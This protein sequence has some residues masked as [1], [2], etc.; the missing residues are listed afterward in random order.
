MKKLEFSRRIN[1]ALLFLLITSNITFAQIVECNTVDCIK[2]AMSTATPGTEIVIAEGNYYPAGKLEDQLGKFVK[3]TSAK[4]G[5]AAKPIILRGKNPAKPPAL[6]CPDNDKYD[7]AVIS[8]NGDYWVLKDLIVKQGD[9]GIML[10]NSNHSKILNVQVTDVGEEAIHLRDGSSNCLIDGCTITFTGRVKPDFGEGIYIGSDRADHGAAPNY[11]PDCKNNTVQNCKIGPNVSAEHLDIKEGTD[12]TIIKN[13]TF[14]AT[15]ISGKNFS[16]SFIDVKGIYC[17]IYKNTFNVN[18]ADKLTSIIDFNNRTTSKFSYKT[19]EK[20]AIFENII[21]LSDK[22]T[23]PTATS[24]GEISKDIH[25]WENKRVPNTPF[26]KDDNTAKSIKE[27]C[28]TWNIVPCP[29]L[30]TDD[31]ELDSKVKI[32]PNPVNAF[33]TINVADNESIQEIVFNDLSGRVL[34]RKSIQSN[35]QDYSFDMGSFPKGMYLV[36][37]KSNEKSWTKKILKQ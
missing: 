7:G 16:D 3:F 24:R 17:Y 29:T 37:L 11:N 21:N 4:N 2:K 30:D 32:G 20:V 12:G 14:D 27:F 13:N 26:I 25:I 1:K 10:D 35:V 6:G 22:G 19:G 34:L 8:I 5:T 15:G 18:N 36:S 9:K 33:L 31:F 23:L 28:P